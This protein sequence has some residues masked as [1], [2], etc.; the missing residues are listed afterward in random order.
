MR[1]NEEYPLDNGQLFSKFALLGN[2]QLAVLKHP[3]V[4]TANASRPIAAVP[5]QTL[6]V[7]C[8]SDCPL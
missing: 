8:D 2:I 4:R 1:Q 3:G 6:M 7:Y 5:F